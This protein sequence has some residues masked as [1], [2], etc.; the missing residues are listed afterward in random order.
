MLIEAR[1]ELGPELL[2]GIEALFDTYRLGG[3]G[4]PKAEPD[5]VSLTFSSGD[6]GVAEAMAQA[7]GLIASA[8]GQPL[9]LSDG[10]GAF[11]PK[12]KGFWGS[13]ATVRSSDPD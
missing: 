1:G 12:K 13:A 11:M 7:L 9:R 4:A 2:G 8:T 5:C 3:F 10:D 6:A